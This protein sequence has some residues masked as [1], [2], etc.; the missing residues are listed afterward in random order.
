MPLPNLV[1]KTSCEILCSLLPHLLAEWGKLQESRGE[2]SHKVEGSWN[3]ESLWKELNGN[4]HV[5]VLQE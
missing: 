2:Q 5:G 4:T 3:H 1:C